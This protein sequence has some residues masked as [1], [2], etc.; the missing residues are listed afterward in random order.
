MS[1][2]GDFLDGPR[3]ENA[4]VE[5]LETAAQHDDAGAL[6]QLA[7]AG[8]GEGLAAR[9][10]GE[11][12]NAGVPF[13]RKIHRRRQHIRPQ[14]HPRPAACRRVVDRAVLVHGKVA[15]LHRI[16]RPYPFRKRTAREA[17]AERSG[18]HL[19]VE[20]EN[21]GAEGHVDG[22]NEKM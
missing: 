16:E 17:D 15:Y 9:G 8:L 1:P 21:G 4:L 19:R 12:G 20:G 6:R 2:I 13:H 3:G 7:H 10:H 14:H 18:E 22:E 11:D 5:T